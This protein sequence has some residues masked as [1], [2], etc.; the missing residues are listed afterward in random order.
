MAS[1]EERCRFRC[2]TTGGVAAGEAVYVCVRPE[3][4]RVLTAPPPA[5][6]TNW[7]RGEVVDSIFLGPLQDCRV[8]WGNVIWRVQVERQQRLRLGTQV[9]LAMAPHHCLC[10]R[11]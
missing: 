6:D 9:W 4:I 2:A 5:T 1:G 11:D 8:Q 7:I 3:N 10:L